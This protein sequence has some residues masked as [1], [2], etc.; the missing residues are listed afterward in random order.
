M[1]YR[2]YWP[3]LFIMLTSLPFSLQA[4]E[5]LLQEGWVATFN[6]RLHDVSGTVTVVDSSTLRFDGFTYDGGG[7]AV[8]FYLGTESESSLFTPELLIGSLLSGNVYDGN[9][10]AFEIGLP[11]E[12]VIQNYSAISVWCVDFAVDFGSGTFRS[13]GDFNGDGNT[14]GEDFLL[15]QRDA[16]AE[17]F[18]V[19]EARYGEQVEVGLAVSLPESETLVL[20]LACFT[21][22]VLQ[23][24]EKRPDLFST[25]F[26]SLSQI[27]SS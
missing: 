26:F 1:R 23:R 20:A 21:I 11:D 2:N 19:W 10:A 13:P 18:A 14:D 27:D 5:V 9:Q 25:T 16:D 4:Q 6:G 15:W 3:F 24:L 12:H 22:L 17:G 7:P 8:Y